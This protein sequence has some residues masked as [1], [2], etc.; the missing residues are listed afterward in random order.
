MISALRWAAMRTILMFPKKVIDKVTNHNLFK[1]KGE[2]FKSGIEP[3]F[4]RFPAALPDRPNLLT[5]S[6][7]VRSDLYIIGSK[8]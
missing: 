8:V 3:R 6:E 1:E 2:P 7:L 4:F 5:A